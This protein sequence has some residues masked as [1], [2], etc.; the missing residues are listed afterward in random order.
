MKNLHLQHPEDTIFTGDLSALHWFTASSTMSVK[1]DGAPAIVW[2]TNPSTGKFFVG[3]KSVFNK[4]KIKINHSH[5]EIDINHEGAVAIILHCA[6]DCLPRT[7]GIVQGDFIGFGGGDTYRPN[8]VT[9]VFD[10]EIDQ[11]I[12]V[13]PHTFY[14]TDGELRDAEAH[15]LCSWNFEVNLRSTDKCKFIQPSAW[16]ADKDF[17][18]IVKFARAMSQMCEFVD[19]KKAEK[20]KKVINTFLKVD[21]VLDAEALATAADCDINL[22]R[23]WK[24]I[25][26]IKMDMLS[27]CSNNGPQAVINGVKIDGEGY[28]RSNNHGMFKLVDR[29]VFSAAN[30]RNGRFA[31]LST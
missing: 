17:T 10:Q 19:D 11:N 16:M 26:T 6:F 5:E 15:P 27:I 12:I 22:M 9:Y 18:D 28:V 29:E 31:K 20:C 3:T 25:H 8:T 4:V 13:A 1:I 30:F 2:G 21:A 7:E 24:L 14:T 23:F